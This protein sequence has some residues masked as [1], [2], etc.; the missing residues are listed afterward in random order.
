M[1]LLARM[2]AR[3]VPSRRASRGPRGAPEVKGLALPRP[4]VAPTVASL[5]AFQRDF[6]AVFLALAEGLPALSASV[7]ALTAPFASLQDPHT[8]LVARIQA[9]VDAMAE[10]SR[11]A[12]NGVLT[13]GEAG[14]EQ[15][16]LLGESATELAG[17]LTRVEKVSLTL[18]LA[19]L[20]ASFNVDALG[21]R[22]AAF[23]AVNQALI[24]VAETAAALAEATGTSAQRCHQAATRLGEG[25]QA[26]ALDLAQVTTDTEARSWT[27][28]MEC[29]QLLEQLGGELEAI[30]SRGREVAEA[31]GVIMVAIQHQDILR[32]GLDHV[33]L[34]LEALRTEAERLAGGAR[35]AASPMAFLAFQARAGRLASDLLGSLRRQ[36]EALVASVRQPVSGLGEAARVFSARTLDQASIERSL[37]AASDHLAQ[38]FAALPEVGV[39]GACQQELA[40]L[41]A[42]LRELRPPLKAMERIP[43]ELDMVA[44]LLRAEI[45]HLDELRGVDRIAEELRGSGND[46]R[47]LNDSA[48]AS[49]ERVAARLP[50]VRAA[51]QRQRVA[52]EE[53]RHLPARLGAPAAEVHQLSAGFREHLG[54]LQGGG[55]GLDRKVAGL[56]AELERFAGALGLTDTVRGACEGWSAE[57]RALEEQ[58]RGRGLPPAEPP[59]TL[60]ALIDGFTLFEHKQ[61]ALAVPAQAGDGPLPPP[62]PLE[63]GAPGELTLF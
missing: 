59:R 15:A 60:R 26:L 46:L 27:A 38:G 24:E 17:Q 28:M 23:T 8:G 50:E 13:H 11:G 40:G 19:G 54:R 1:S 34:V 4:D 53:L 22:G 20:N 32:Q 52:W 41:E 58:L 25:Q 49:V 36:L 3:A 51:L 55:Q 14:L 21:Q 56:L 61:I 30:A 44:I 10:V 16:R 33:I 63:A 18:R 43:L 2:V 57:A 45:A 9:Q 12:T 7:Q 39:V 37:S 47:A 48:G 31:T 5:R 42:H 35:S 29:T 62:P 6:E